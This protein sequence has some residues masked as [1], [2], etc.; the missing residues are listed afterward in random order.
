LSWY[1]AKLI[2]GEDPNFLTR[3]LRQAIERGDFPK[4]K[5]CV[6]IMPEAE[7]YTRP[8]AFDCT[9]VWKHDEFP[10]IEVGEIVLNRNPT[11]YF[12][13]VEQVA[14]SPA[15]TPPGIAFSPDRL[16]Q[17]RLFIYDDTQHHRLG[18]NHKQLF[19]NAPHG[20]PMKT[21]FTGGLGQHEIRNKFPHYWPSNF[22]GLQPDPRFEEPP[23]KVTGDVGHYNWPKEGTDWDYFGQIGDFFRTLIPEDKEHLCENIAVSWEKVPDEI[24]LQLLP[25]LYK[26][27]AEYGRMTEQKWKA[28][29]EGKVPRTEAELLVASLNKMLLG[30]GTVT[31]K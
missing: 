16:L 23:M 4:W 6:Q 17:V 25:N 15:T 7:G 26:C 9:K 14:F 29:K 13:E 21:M 3:D 28:R 22:G 27:D 12:S 2:A 20:C 8:E 30:T 11:D 1:E 31:A 10:L 24:C 18:P 5:L 19:I